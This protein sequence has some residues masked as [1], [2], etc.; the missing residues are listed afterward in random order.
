MDTLHVVYDDNNP[1]V[2]PNAIELS[3]NGIDQNC[4]GEDHIAAT[5]VDPTEAFGVQYLA[6]IAHQQTH[7]EN[8]T[9]SDNVV[10]TLH[11]SN[12]WI[13]SHSIPSKTGTNS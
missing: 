5:S 12:V 1:N 9:Y 13:D 6:P 10:Y 11:S 8:H 3:L 2:Y 7:P 4:D